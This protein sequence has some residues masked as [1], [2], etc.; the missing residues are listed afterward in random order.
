MGADAD[1]IAAARLLLDQLGVTLADLQSAGVDRTP[2]AS[3]ADYLPRVIA[4]A[5]PGARKTYGSYWQRMATSW[6]DRRWTRSRPA[7]SRPCNRN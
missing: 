5:G 7:T 3:V 4:A 1:R 2:A 6:G